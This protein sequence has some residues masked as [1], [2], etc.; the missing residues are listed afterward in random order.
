MS[1]H[2]APLPV[3]AA[4]V[5][6]SSLPELLLLA[7][8]ARRCR[9]FCPFGVAAAERMARIASCS[10]RR[11]RETLVWGGRPVKNKTTSRRSVKNAAHIRATACTRVIRSLRCQNPGFGHLDPNGSGGGRKNELKKIGLVVL[12]LLA[13]RRDFKRCGKSDS[14]HQ[15]GA[16][17]IPRTL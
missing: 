10:P 11:A 12:A 17:W 4:E 15:H 1:A 3:L 2:S 8:A 6:A 16:L 5:L 7:P 13:K 14:C 9:P